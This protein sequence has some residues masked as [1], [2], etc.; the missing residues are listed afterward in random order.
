MSSNTTPPHNPAASWAG[1]D[2]TRCMLR[3]SYAGDPRIRFKHGVRSHAELAAPA[4][5][6]AMGYLAQ[7]N[8]LTI[9][10][11]DGTVLH[12]RRVASL[13]PLENET[14]Y[15]VPYPLGRDMYA[16]PLEDLEQ[17]R[18]IKP[19]AAHNTPYWT[20]VDC[21]YKVLLNPMGNVMHWGSP[22]ECREFVQSLCL[23][24]D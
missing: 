11:T 14:V 1:F 19:A 23:A 13:P 8:T 7:S 10:H 3:L 24:D 18:W 12:W 20:V 2:Y 4:D 6:P 15:E 21:E 5:E 16:V 17:G 22:E 9:H